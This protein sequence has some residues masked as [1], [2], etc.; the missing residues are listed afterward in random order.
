M[1][2]ING[3]ISGIYAG[4]TNNSELIAVAVDQDGR[5]LVSGGGGGGGGG[6]TPAPSIRPIINGTIIAAAVSQVV[7]NAD[8]T[9]VYVEFFP[10]AV[11][12][13]INFGSPAGIDT[14]ILIRANDGGWYS[15]ANLSVQSSVTIW[16][17]TAGNKFTI[18]EG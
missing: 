12:Y 18:L 9:R 16:C 17:A 3:L 8:S 5:L 1:G 10:A 4:G 7:L 13:W 11:D 15:P 6:Y 14:G 2:V